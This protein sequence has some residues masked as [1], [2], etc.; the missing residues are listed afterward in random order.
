MAM[1]QAKV[2]SPLCTLCT[3]ARRDHRFAVSKLP[4]WE[5]KYGRCEDLA[6]RIAI[7]SNHR[8]SQPRAMAAPDGD[9]A[10]FDLVCPVALRLGLL[11]LPDRSGHGGLFAVVGELDPVGDTEEPNLS[12][13]GASDLW[14]GQD[15]DGDFNSA[16][17]DADETSLPPLTRPGMHAI[18]YS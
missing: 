7:G 1:D 6:D 2:N 10:L 4:R 17:L 18:A 11:C 12:G 9:A 16:V 8:S 15:A 14:I 13:W 3:L 5:R